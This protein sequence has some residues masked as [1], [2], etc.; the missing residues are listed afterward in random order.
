[1]ARTKKDPFST[2]TATAT[3]KPK[4]KYTKRNKAT[5]SDEAYVTITIPT[6]LAFEFGKR[7]A[8]HTAWTQAKAGTI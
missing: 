7:V 4:R 3:A 8:E 1:M 5:K 2:E 6:A